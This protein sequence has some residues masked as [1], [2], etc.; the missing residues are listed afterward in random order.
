MDPAT[1][2]TILLSL[3]ATVRRPNPVPTRLIFS[4]DTHGDRL[5]SQLE[6]NELDAP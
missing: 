2:V 6:R 5:A 4:N 1:L 3:R